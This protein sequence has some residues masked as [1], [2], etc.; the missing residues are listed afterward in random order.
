MTACDRPGAEP[1]A[2]AES[3]DPEDWDK[4]HAVARLILDNSV[5]YLRDVRERPVWRQMPGAA[6]LRLSKR[7]SSAI[8]SRSP[9][10][11]AKPPPT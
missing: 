4:S 6:S 3:L 1:Q 10:S 11:G 9:T 2:R 5:A 7:R 8:L